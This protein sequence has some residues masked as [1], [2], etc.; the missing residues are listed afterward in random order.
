MAAK[1]KILVVDDDEPFGAMLRE[2]FEGAGY[3][4]A[5]CFDPLGGSAAVA[6]FIPDLIILDIDM[7]AGGGRMLFRNVRNHAALAARPILV[8][9]GTDKKDSVWLSLGA[10]PDDRTW[11]MPKPVQLPKLLTAVKNLT[12]DP[13]QA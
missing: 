5:L 13:P 1:K 8:V 10:Q 7:P 2:A 12:Q 9:S 3:E 6:K 4:V 11:F